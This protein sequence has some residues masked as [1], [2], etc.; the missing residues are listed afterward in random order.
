MI[1]HKNHKVLRIMRVGTANVKS[2]FIHFLNNANMISTVEKLGDERGLLKLVT[3]KSQ[4]K[5]LTRLLPFDSQLRTSL[6]V[7]SKSIF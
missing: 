4:S 5:I 6:E 3:E 2:V 7:G 1:T